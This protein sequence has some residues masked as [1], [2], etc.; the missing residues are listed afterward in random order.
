MHAHGLSQYDGFSPF[1]T[2]KMYEEKV[3]FNE[4]WRMITQLRDLRNLYCLY[5]YKT[6]LSKESVLL[7]AFIIVFP[8]HTPF[9]VDTR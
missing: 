7:T 3:I 9:T 2:I 1:Q 8:F 6:R 4:Q 5:L